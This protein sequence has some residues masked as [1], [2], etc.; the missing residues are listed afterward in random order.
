M[1][2]I[3]SASR[4]RMALLA[5]AA[6]GALLPGPLPARAEVGVASAVNIDARGQ[7]PGASPR[8]ISLGSNIVFNEKITTD[9]AGLV[10]I[11]LLDGTTFTVGPNS[12]LSIDEFVY[13]PSTGDAKVVASLTKGVFRFVGARTSQQDG[14][15]TVKTPVGTIG[16]RGGVANFSYDPATGEGKAALVA[17][18]SLTILDGDGTKR[19]VYETGFTAVITRSEGGGTTTTIRKSTKEE[20]GLIQKQLASKPGQNGG[21]SGAPPND[22]QT[23]QVS[24]TNSSLPDI[25]NFP[26]SERPGLDKQV[27]EAINDKTQDVINEDIASEEQ[28]NARLLTNQDGF[29]V[30]ETFTYPYPGKV[31]LVG[32]T[33]ASDRKVRLLKEGGRLKL[34][35]GSLDLPDYSNV[36]PDQGDAE[37]DETYPALDVIEIPGSAGTYQGNGVGGFVYAGRGDFVTYMLDFASNPENLVY[38][39]YGTPTT[40]AQLNQ[41]TDATP[42]VREYELTAD[43]IVGSAAPFFNSSIYDPSNDMGYNYPVQTFDSSNLLVVEAPDLGD[44]RALQTWIHIEG[45]GETQRSGAFV[46]TGG[47]TTDSNGFT[48]LEM[49]RRGTFRTPDSGP[50]NMRGGFGTIAGGGGHFFG[51]NAD[52]F[53]IGAPLDPDNPDFPLDYYS[54]AP[55]DNGYYTGNPEDGYAGGAPFGTHHVGSLVEETPLTEF[56][57]PGHPGRTTRDVTGFI[58]G[59]GEASVDGYLETPYVLT[60]EGGPNFTLGLNATQN[61]VVAEANVYDTFDDSGLEAMLIRFGR[62]TEQDNTVSGGGSAFIDDDRFGAQKNNN[63]TN[64][65]VKHDG[66]DYEAHT[67]EFTPGSYL[68]SGRA[69]PIEGYEHCTDCDFIDWGWWGT[70]V[71]SEPEGAARV[72]YVHMGTWVAGEIADPNGPGLTGSA[73]YSGS[74]I[75]TVSR[76]TGATYIARGDVGMSIDLATRSGDLSITNFDGMNVYAPISDAS[77][78]SQ[79]LFTGSLYDNPGYGSSLVSGSVTGA[80]VN[81]GPNVAAGMIGNF[82]FA[83]DGVQAAGT[84]AGTRNP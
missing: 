51:Q 42:V 61:T 15:A 80:L 6:V 50:V 16:I 19:V 62:Y 82:G 72:D 58:A 75:G 9:G 55:L 40:P 35:D 47:L 24:E 52:H 77:T 45:E 39:I 64:T 27:D 74:A 68:V 81:D 29:V 41:F 44:V 4:A 34:S 53:V 48:Q 60:G 5:G 18:K 11:L 36:D 7:P 3:A 25:M 20:T 32:S 38:I 71:E 69:N 22:E 46:A 49:G 56:G 28:P 12:Q 30:D 70:R 14:G 31:G 67:G 17:G 84:I 10:Q 21:N 8:V 43:P 57:Q 33:P 66:G 26:A 13:D 2:P 76:D 79:T 54:D 1:K 83:G 23:Q 59:M 37:G 65:Q 78:L 73:S 63:P